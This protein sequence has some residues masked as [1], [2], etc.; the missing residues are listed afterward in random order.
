MFLGRPTYLLA[1]LYF[2]GILLSF[3]FFSPPNLR[4][5]W[6]ELNQNQ[7]HA[8]K[9]LRFE[10][11]CPL[12]SQIG[13]PK[14]TFLGRLRNLTANLTTYIF[15]VKH[16][17][18]N[19]SSALITTRGLLHRPKMSWTLVHKRLQKLLHSFGFLTTLTLNGEFFWMK[20]D[21]RQSDKGAGKYEGSPTLPKNC[22]N[23]S[24]QTA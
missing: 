3:F 17:I 14:S 9:K 21:I 20:R 22:M 24:P 11:E 12:P 18:D 13:G 4:V 1:D 2:I 6:T 19:R 8:R 16:D 23:F 15:R 5:R 10:N 7:P